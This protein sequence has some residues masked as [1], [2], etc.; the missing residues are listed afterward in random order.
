MVSFNTQPALRY[1]HPRAAGTEEQEGDEQFNLDNVSETAPNY[2]HWVADLVEP[3][4]GESVL[5]VGAG[6]GSVTQHLIDGR[7][8]VATDLSESSVA[9]MSRRFEREPSVRVVRAG[10]RTWDPGEQFDS[11]LMINVLEHIRDDVG[12]L[13]SLRR[14][15]KPG[16]SVVIYVPALN[17][18][19]GPWDEMA[20]HF[21]RYSK[22]RLRRVLEGASLDVVELRYANALAV[23]AWALFSLVSRV[24]TNGDRSLS[25]WDRTAVPLTRLIETRFAPPIGLNLLGVG[26]VSGMRDTAQPS[27][28]ERG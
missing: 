1:V 2:L 18:L 13:A 23:P 21:R 28:T 17:G 4:L 5:E 24:D 10:L 11:V 3:H 27:G 7:R 26:R 14:H 9:T 25:I 16:G 6:T 22:W 20:G 19:Y 15:V 12:V 8:L